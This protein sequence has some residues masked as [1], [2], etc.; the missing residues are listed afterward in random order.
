MYYHATNVE[1]ISR[2]MPGVSN[3]LNP[4]VYFTAKR[5]NSLV[6]L[7]NAVEA[8]C[9]DVDFRHVGR[10]YRWNSYGFDEGGLNFEWH[11]LF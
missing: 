1:G 3:Q 5:E 9:N 10:Y 6:Y 4:R 7:A 8:Y 11:G 2:L